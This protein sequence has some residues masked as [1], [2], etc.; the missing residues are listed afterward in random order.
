METTTI[1]TEKTI[2]ERRNISL[3]FYYAIKAGSINTYCRVF[4]ES[5]KRQGTQCDQ[6]IDATQIGSMQYAGRLSYDGILPPKAEIISGSEYKDAMNKF[7]D[8]ITKKGEEVLM[9]TTKPLEL[10]PEEKEYV[11][12]Q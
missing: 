7:L 9:E 3:P 2:V 4:R 12:N 8:Y 1:A 10:N 5:G 6:I 11:Q